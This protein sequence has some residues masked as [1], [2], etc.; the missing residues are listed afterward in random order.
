MYL[1]I[2]KML[3]LLYFYHVYIHHIYRSEGWRYS[4]VTEYVSRHSRSWSIS[5]STTP[6]Y[7]KKMLEIINMRR[8]NKNKK[9]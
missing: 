3:Y 4:S 8:L 6:M 5:A 1:N 9:L 7:Q 2:K